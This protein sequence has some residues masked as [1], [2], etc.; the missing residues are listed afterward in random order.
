MFFMPI[1]QLDADTRVEILTPDEFNRRYDVFAKEASQVVEGCHDCFDL[2]HQHLMVQSYGDGLMLLRDK[3]NGFQVG[4][5]LISFEAFHGLA[6]DKIKTTDGKITI[7][8][9]GVYDQE[10]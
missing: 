9:T 7:P 6:L 10:Q 3:P 1:A 2:A 5:M 8:K 4:E